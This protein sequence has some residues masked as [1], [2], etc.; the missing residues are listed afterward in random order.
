MSGVK[1]VY[2]TMIAAVCLGACNGRGPTPGSPAHA[3]EVLAAFTKPGANHEALTKTLRPKPDD[4][5]AVFVGDAARKVQVWEDRLWA[6]GGGKLIINPAPAQTE[7]TIAV[8]AQPELWMAE[9]EG[10]GQRCLGAHASIADKLQPGAVLACARFVQPGE[11][12]GFRVE[13]LAWVNGHWAFF[14]TPF[15]PLE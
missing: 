3:A 14:P 4:Y 13:A 6:A 2:G 7:I 5:A 1:G 15:P 12:L 11:R 10:N 8:V 9:R